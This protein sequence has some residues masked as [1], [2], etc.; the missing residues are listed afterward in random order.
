M[1]VNNNNAPKHN[2]TTK[3]GPSHHFLFVVRNS[4]NSRTSDVSPSDSAICE[5]SVLG[6]SGSVTTLTPD[7]LAGF[8]DV[9][10]NA[11][12]FTRVIHHS[13]SHATEQ[14]YNAAMI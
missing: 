13:A 3:I 5:K 2:R 14:K 12:E 10:S 6:S 4:R 7:E 1:L 11:D 8:K 9:S